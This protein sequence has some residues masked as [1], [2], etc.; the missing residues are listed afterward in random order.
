MTEFTLTLLTLKN[1]IESI[2]LNQFK[3]TKIID[4]DLNK[5]TNK[6]L[7]AE[8]LIS[9]VCWGPCSFNKPLRGDKTIREIAPEITHGQFNN[10]C[11][12]I[13]LIIQQRMQL[14]L[15]Y[16]SNEDKIIEKKAR[17]VRLNELSQSFGNLNIKE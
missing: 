12:I 16:P 10:L 13:E 17:K 6:E 7:F 3:E 11:K 9:S 5:V 15:S 2:D 4:Y 1:L 14:S 8:Y